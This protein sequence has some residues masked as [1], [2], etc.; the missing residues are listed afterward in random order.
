MDCFVAESVKNLN[1]VI[2][3]FL[4]LTQKI[5]ENKMKQLDPDH[6]TLYKCQEDW[7]MGSLMTDYTRSI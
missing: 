5:N 6:M 3:L 2:V 1:V 7:I 4:C